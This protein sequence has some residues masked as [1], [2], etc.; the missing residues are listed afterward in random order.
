MELIESLISTIVER[1]PMKAQIAIVAM[2]VILVL[3]AVG[4]ILLR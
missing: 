1:L 2:V 4:Y 3:I